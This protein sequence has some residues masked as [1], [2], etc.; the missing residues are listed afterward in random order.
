MSLPHF[1]R[2]GDLPVGV[3]RASLIEV[4]TRFGHATPQR[5]LVSTRLARIYEL[6]KATGKLDRFIIFGS[7]ITTEPNPNDV[8][9]I[10]IMRDDFR[11]EA[12]PAKAKPLFD[13][14]FAQREFGASVFA[15]R[16]SHILFESVDKFV[17]NWQIKRDKT[18]RGIVEII[19]GELT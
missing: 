8:D 14:A 13:H 19:T 10:L 1:D 4:L 3:H 7:Y 6:A 2:N 18:R 17:E 9:I 15:I 5:K 12:C 11:Q 16:P